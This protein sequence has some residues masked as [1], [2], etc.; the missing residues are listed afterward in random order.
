MPLQFEFDEVPDN[1]KRL[2]GYCCPECG[3]LVKMYG[4]KFNSNMALALIFLYHNKARGFIHLEN[5]MKAAGKQRCGDASYLRHYRLI[6]AYKG[7][8][9]DGSP[10]NGFYKIT[11]L[12]I[13]F[14]EQKYRVQKTFLI[15]N[16][17]IEGFHGPE[18]GITEALGTKF[19]YDELMLAI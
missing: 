1:D 17:K 3:Q 7:E 12:G 4:R 13:Q 18:I 10:R 8:R 14:C 6:E 15:F 11:G 19:K 16:N 2:R 5:E 9:T